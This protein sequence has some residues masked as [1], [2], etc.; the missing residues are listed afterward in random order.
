MAWTSEQSCAITTPIFVPSALKGW[1][2]LA[3]SCLDSFRHTYI[4]ELTFL[5]D[6]ESMRQKQQN[7][8][9]CH[10]FILLGFL[11][12]PNEEPSLSSRSCFSYLLKTHVCMQG[13]R[14]VHMLSI[15]MHS[16]SCKNED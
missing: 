3:M 4:E 1:A 2:R 14:G 7:E 6:L 11:V 13:H 9:G 16:C 5:H 8:D 12:D 15:R 10:T